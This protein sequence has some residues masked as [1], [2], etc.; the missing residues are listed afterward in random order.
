MFNIKDFYGENIATIN[1]NNIPQ[2]DSELVIFNSKEGT[3]KKYL[4]TNISYNY[5]I[6]SEEDVWDFKEHICVN[7]ISG[8]KGR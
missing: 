2:I 1:S 3:T 5:N 8:Y 6:P 4:V 7:V